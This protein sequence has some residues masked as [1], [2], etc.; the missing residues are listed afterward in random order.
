MFLFL[1]S[2]NAI[3]HGCLGLLSL[4]LE[5]KHIEASVLNLRVDIEPAPSPQPWPGFTGLP[6]WLYPM[7]FYKQSFD[8]NG[9]TFLLF[10]L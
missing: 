10:L 9:R 5:G 1:A 6:F 2:S 3:D 8:G 7:A 4:F